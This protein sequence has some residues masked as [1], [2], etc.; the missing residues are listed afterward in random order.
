M[1]EAFAEGGIEPDTLQELGDLCTAFRPIADPVH[2]QWFEDR[3]RDGHAR[4][5]TGIGVLPDD[6]E[7]P[8]RTGEPAAL[9][10][11]EICPRELD[12][13]RGR[14]LQPQQRPGQG[15]LAAA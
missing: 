1:R 3:L 4:I 14:G 10:P 2:D 8:A 9:E 6:L 13:A 15:A 7:V 5:E 11:G 12:G